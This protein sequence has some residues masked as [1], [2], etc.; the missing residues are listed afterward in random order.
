MRQKLRITTKHFNLYLL[1]VI[2]IVVAVGLSLLATTSAASPYVSSEA[3]AGTLSGPAT[4]QADTAA[5]GG[6]YVQFG[7]FSASTNNGDAYFSLS[8]SS[9]SYSVG[10]SFNVNIYETAQTSDNVQGV[11]V[12]LA[13]DSSD[14]QFNSVSET[15][16]PF[17][18]VAK[19]SGGNGSVQ[20]AEASTATVSG[21]QQ[22]VATIN[23]TVITANSPNPTTISIA[24]GSDIQTA[25][26]TSVW[27]GA[28]TSASFT[29]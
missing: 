9:G 5:S 13:Y 14:L 7:S 12:I 8:P 22:L 3:E 20:V 18:L 25:S 19:S 24:N 15:G 23:F 4:I 16:S 28:L 26:L 1:S 27:N 21:G 6:K 11:N 17:S 2:V 29:L 10:S